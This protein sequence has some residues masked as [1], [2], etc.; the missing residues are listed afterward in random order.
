MVLPF[1]TQDKQD[2]VQ[3]VFTS[4][5]TPNGCLRADTS[6]C[7]QSECESDNSMGCP[8]QSDTFR[9]HFARK[10]TTIGGCLRGVSKTRRSGAIMRRKDKIRH[11]YCP[12][13]KSPDTFMAKSYCN[14]WSYGLR[15]A[16]RLRAPC[17]LCDVPVAK[18]RVDENG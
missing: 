2:H 6:G 8:D 9:S 15:H 13:R 17:R 12:D 16:D 3:G 11:H 18:E 14:F 7:S 10:G 5:L 4:H 1:Q